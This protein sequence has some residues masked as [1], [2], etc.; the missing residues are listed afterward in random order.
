MQKIKSNKAN[1]GMGS[2]LVLIS[3]VLLWGAVILFRENC[4]FFQTMYTYHFSGHYLT[5]DIANVNGLLW[6]YFMRTLGQYFHGYI[7]PVFVV[8]LPGI[9]CLA[10]GIFKITGKELSV[11]EFL[12]DEKKEKTFL[13]SLIALA[14]IAMLVIHFIVM[15]NFTF[16]TDEYSYLFQ[17]EILASGKLQAVAPKPPE[18]FS[19]ANVVINGDKLYSKYTLGMPFLLALGVIPRVPFMVNILF[20]LGSL[21]LIYS[22]AKEIFNKQAGA[23]ALVITIFSPFFLLMAATY[24]PHTSSGFFTL[25]IVSSILKFS[26]EKKWV[27]PIMAGFAIFMML[28][29]RPADAAIVVLGLSPWIL[30]ILFKSENKA[31]TLKKVSLTVL[32]MI[33]GVGLLMLVNKIQNGNPFLFSFIK[34]RAYEKWGFGHI[35]HTPAKGAWNVAISY[36]RMGFWVFPFIT[37]GA[38]LSLFQKKIESIFLVIPPLGFLSF[39]FFFYA[40]GLVE[41]GARFYY[42]AFVILTISAAGGLE[43]I[44]RLI[45]KYHW[46]GKKNIIPA[47]LILS[48]LFVCFG[49][50][51]TLF[52]T[53]NI[54]YQ[55]KMR[56][57][58]TL[59]N[60]RELQGKTVT[61]IR[62]TPDKIVDAMIRNHYNYKNQKNLMAVF[63]T[64]KNNR[65][66][67][68][69]FPE[70]KIWLAYFDYGK[71]RFSLVPFNPDTPESPMDYMFAAINYKNSM[72]RIEE[73][74]ASFKKA[75]ELAPGN[76]S[77]L[78]NLGFFYFETEQYEKG[79]ETYREVLKNAPDYADAYYYL[80]RCLGNLGKKQEAITVLDEM[81]KKFPK[82]PKAERAKDWLNYYRKAGKG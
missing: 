67:V 19:I 59:Q 27:Y 75:V 47:A 54:Q 15:M 12:K 36:F 17:A 14:F 35:G 33:L 38:V 25:L 30:Y 55:A 71:N 32:A 73:A 31:D 8:L 43:S 26:R 49:A 18:S 76:P 62:D 44:P 16:T 48:I 57:I 29:I 78:F 39:Y 1:K 34:Y 68:E 41:F 65:E 51:P 66:I 45:E 42:P 70:R 28:Q 77:L 6:A 82:S 4:A 24:F 72:E 80:G 56:F 13:F 2:L 23:L 74:E 3:L 52:K 69:N 60:S 7:L 61:I 11:F 40:M 58:N 5:F 22:I 63:L 20:A 21:C 79:M 64:P 37:L 81:V 10:L 53:V 50:F 46:R 9:L